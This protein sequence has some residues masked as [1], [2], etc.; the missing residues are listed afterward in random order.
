MR[1]GPGG[2]MG[3]SEVLGPTTLLLFVREEVTLLQG[4]G[5]NLA[6]RETLMQENR[7]ELLGQLMSR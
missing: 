3:L 6:E 7:A 2:E 4:A 5:N 1:V